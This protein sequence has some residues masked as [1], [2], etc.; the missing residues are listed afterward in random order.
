MLVSI[1][2]PRYL[3]FVVPVTLVYGN[4]IL[5]TRP[6]QCMDNFQLRRVGCQQPPP[7][8]ENGNST[9]GLDLEHFKLTFENWPPPTLPPPPPS[10]GNGNFTSGLDLENFKSTFENWPSPTPPPPPPPKWVSQFWDW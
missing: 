1:I 6:T 2:Q 7:P 5:M 9:S 10:P 8:L 4:H 3:K